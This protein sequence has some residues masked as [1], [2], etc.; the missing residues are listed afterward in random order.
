MIDSMKCFDGS[1]KVLEIS[2]TRDEILMELQK[3]W[4][5]QWAI[6]LDVVGGRP[7]VFDIYPK[8]YIQRS[9]ELVRALN[10]LG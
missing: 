4:G 3:M 6:T 9:N 7:D 2:A 8:G 10:R 1:Q 5:E